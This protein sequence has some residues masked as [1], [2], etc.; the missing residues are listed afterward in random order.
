MKLECVERTVRRTSDLYHKARPPDLPSAV[1]YFAQE[2]PKESLFE[3]K[4]S[5]SFFISERKTNQNDLAKGDA[6]KY[7]WFEKML[8]LDNSKLRC[9]ENPFVKNPNQDY[10]IK[11]KNKWRGS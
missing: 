11:M 10:S 9:W 4:T 7:L 3:S 6:S 5:S 1:T 2:K 8:I